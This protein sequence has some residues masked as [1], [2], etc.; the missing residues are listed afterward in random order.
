[1]KKLKKITLETMKNDFHVLNKAFLKTI[2]GGGYV[3]SYS[4]NGGTITN[5]TYGDYNYAVFTSNGGQ[6]LVLE[7]VHV[8]GNTL[9][10]QE[11]DTA[12]Y[13]NGEIRIGSDWSDFGFSDLV[14][15]YG[16]YLQ[17]QDM[18]AADYWSGAVGSAWNI[19]QDDGEGHSEMP[20]EQDA[21]NR[22]NEYAASYYGYPVSY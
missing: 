10:F 5:W 20:F 15:E 16:H 4:I 6:V 7:G 2:L 17:S 19:W 22:G 21:T 8:G 12:C 13:F 1:M 14:H 9:P 18:S 3:G 11:S